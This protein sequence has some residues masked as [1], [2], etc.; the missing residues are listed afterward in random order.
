MFSFP[1][2]PPLKVKPP[3]PVA[4]RG[5]GTA[6]PRLVKI[7]VITSIIFWW[8]VVS[9]FN[10]ILAALFWKILKPMKYSSLIAGLWLFLTLWLGYAVGFWAG[11]QIILRDMIQKALKGRQEAKRKV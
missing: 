10:L 8:C 2:P 5:W 6:D 7:V 3:C 9:V 1:K 11:R 4:V